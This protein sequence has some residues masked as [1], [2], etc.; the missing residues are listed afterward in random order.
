MTTGFNTYASITVIDKIK[1]HGKLQ[2]SKEKLS[3]TMSSYL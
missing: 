1:K 2:S 3:C